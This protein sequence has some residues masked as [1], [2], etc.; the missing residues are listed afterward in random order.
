MTDKDDERL[1][2]IEARIE[3]GSA[4]FQD[5]YGQL[6]GVNQ[7]L[8]KLATGQNETN[9]RLDRLAETVESSNERL[10]RLERFA[11]ETNHRLDLLTDVTK[12]LA[13]GQVVTNERLDRLAEE[14]NARLDRLAEATTA[15]LDRLIEVTTRS[16]T[17]WVGRYESHE[18]RIG[19]VEQRLDELEKRT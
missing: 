15:R 18:A 13:A 17:D 8:D 14:T 19:S 3:T 7:R 5:V 16:Y 2:R 1:E 10:D 11:G 4:L 6:D 9:V 12:G